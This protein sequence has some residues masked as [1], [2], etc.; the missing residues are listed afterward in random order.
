MRSLQKKLDSAKKT[1]RDTDIDVVLSKRTWD[2]M[3]PLVCRSSRV[4]EIGTGPGTLL[5]NLVRLQGIVCGLD[6]SLSCCKNAKNI[7][8]GGE[9]LRADGL[10]APFPNECFDIIFCLQTIEHV[11]DHGLCYEV[12][13]LLKTGGF[14]VVS[15]VLRKAGALYF[16]RSRHMGKW[17]M[18][19]DHLR[20]YSCEEELYQVL[21]SAGFACR[22][23]NVLKIRYSVLIQ[24]H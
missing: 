16:H 21:T 18:G 8:P 14:F 22:E 9:I 13:R 6:L 11:D 5:Y 3:Q 17:A 1:Y 2:L 19:E 4:L 12:N 20:E 10:R 7:I 15:S 23:S 24:T